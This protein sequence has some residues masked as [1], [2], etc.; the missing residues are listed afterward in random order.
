MAHPMTIGAALSASGFPQV[1]SPFCWLHIATLL[2]GV[3][4]NPDTRPRGED[5]GSRITIARRAHPLADGT[6]RR[7]PRGWRPIC[8]GVP[9]DEAS[10]ASVALHGAPRIV[11]TVDLRGALHT[12]RPSR[13]ST[14]VPVQR[15]PTTHDGQCPTAPSLTRLR[16]GSTCDCERTN[17]R[18]SQHGIPKRGDRCLPF[19]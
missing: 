2:D 16:G 12:I 6:P 15:F 7:G 13:V 19:G 11:L 10:A 14:Q 5:R 17:A 8:F 1:A 18:S 3:A 4:E 9:N